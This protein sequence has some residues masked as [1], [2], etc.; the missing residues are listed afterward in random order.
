MRYES[1]KESEFASDN[2]SVARYF[3]CKVFL[4]GPAC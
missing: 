1:T 3:V 2:D 4:D